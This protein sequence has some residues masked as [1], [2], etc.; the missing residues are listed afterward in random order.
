VKRILGILFM[1]VVLV[2]YFNIFDSQT[3]FAE[4]IVHHQ[5]TAGIQ[6]VVE[7]QKEEQPIASIQEPEKNEGKAENVENSKNNEP[8][9]SSNAGIY[10]ITQVSRG[11]N[12]LGDKKHNT[13]LIVLSDIMVKQAKGE[14]VKVGNFKSYWNQVGYHLQTR[15]FDALS[16]GF[17]NTV[18]QDISLVTPYSFMKYLYFIK[19]NSFQE[20]TQGEID[21]AK[22]LCDIV[23]VTIDS[24]PS[25]T[26]IHFDFQPAPRIVNVV[27][28]IND[29][30]YQ[31]IVSNTR[32]LYNDAHFDSYVQVFGFPINLFNL[33][34]A[35]IEILIADGWQERCSIKINQSKLK[36][37]Q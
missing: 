15:D 27:L 30:I 2:G 29:K 34:N 14:S 35:P 26:E 21:N 8:I 18:K 32:T 13:S 37:M 36:K 17:R 5:R 33:E 16:H 12:I 4:T 7:E 23:Y 6:P 10:N 19:N 22:N 28:R 24:T 31:P 1:L 20:P 9:K 25:D 3:V 11:N